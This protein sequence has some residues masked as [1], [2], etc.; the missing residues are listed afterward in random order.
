M[1]NR[2][3]KI[4]SFIDNFC[5]EHFSEKC[6]L[7]RIDPLPDK[8]LND[9]FPIVEEHVELNGGKQIFGWCIHVWRRVIIEAE[10]HSIWE[11][12]DGVLIDITPKKEKGTHIVF[13][14]DA[15]ANYNGHQIDNIRK[16]LTNDPDT[17][18]YIAL[19]EEYFRLTNEGELAGQHG[20][21]TLDS[22]EFA[23]LANQLMTVESR[24]ISKYG[25]K[26]ILL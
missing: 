5:K 4:P 17:A 13:V 1:K 24:L 7:V 8:P 23:A 19:F 14:H 16:P 18:K 10:F 3:K 20:L 22:K 25:N 15:N 21:I 11:R 12:P 2:K 6:Q 26:R 9:C